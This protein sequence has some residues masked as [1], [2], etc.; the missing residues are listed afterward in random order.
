MPDSWGGVRQRQPYGLFGNNLAASFSLGHLVLHS[1]WNWPVTY[2]CQ[3][4]YL[5]N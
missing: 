1:V 4:A 2:R 3:I 5:E